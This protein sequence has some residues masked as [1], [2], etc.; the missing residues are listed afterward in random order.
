MS[1]DNVATPA[2]AAS[3]TAASARFTSENMRRTSGSSWAPIFIVAQKLSRDVSIAFN[4]FA[5]RSRLAAGESVRSWRMSIRQRA[6][7][8]A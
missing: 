2:L 8:S 5:A 1:E 3:H 4:V 6:A 7:K